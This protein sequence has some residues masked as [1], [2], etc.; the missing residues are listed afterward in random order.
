MWVY[1]NYC[2][3]NKFRATLEVGFGEQCVL[4]KKA[5]DHCR[6]YRTGE[7]N[8]EFFKQGLLI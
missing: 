2:H 7:Q 5:S 8:A 1:F 4:G 3:P 6:P